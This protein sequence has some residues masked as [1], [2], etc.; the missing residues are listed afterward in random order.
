MEPRP[1]NVHSVTVEEISIGDAGNY[2]TLPE[3]RQKHK[4]EVSKTQQINL[5]AILH[6]WQIKLITKS[7]LTNTVNGK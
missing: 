6:K 5:Y 1:Y 4:L 3:F 7:I 2:F